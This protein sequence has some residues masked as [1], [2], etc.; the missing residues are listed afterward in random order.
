[1]FGDFNDPDSM[2][3]RMKSEHYH[4]GGRGYKLLEYLGTEPNVIYLSKVD[5]Y[6][7]TAGD[8]HA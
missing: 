8:G 1:V 3:S 6:A 7:E 2:I 4:E 5:M